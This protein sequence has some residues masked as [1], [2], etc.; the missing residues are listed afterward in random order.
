M[1]TNQTL[2]RVRHIIGDSKSTPPIPAIIPVS[3]STFL[4]GVKNGRFP[5]PV[6]VEGCTFWKAEEIY[7]WVASLGQNEG[8]AK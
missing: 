2:L 3:R 4:A 8:G 1:L 6:R 7:G 5:K